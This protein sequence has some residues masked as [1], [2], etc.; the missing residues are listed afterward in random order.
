M[1]TFF[2]IFKISAITFLLISNLS[3]LL[4]RFID[5]PTT[6]FIQQELSDFIIELK[7]METVELDWI[8]Y[9]N[10]SDFMKIAVIAS[11]DQKFADHFGFDFDQIEKAYEDIERG[12]RFRGASTISQQTAKNIFLWKGQNII[13][14]GFEAYFTLLL[15]IYWSKER[16][17]EVY[18]NIAQ[19]GDKIYGVGKA[20]KFYFNKSPH[21]LTKSESALLAAVLPSPI[22]YKAAKPTA[23]LIGRRNRIMIQMDLI[24]GKSYLK[25][26]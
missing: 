25:R 15:E 17:L 23:F 26:L 22:R 14:K 4:F 24:G 11:E 19:F 13:R 20:S 1:K 12:K 16:I 10:I 9:D 18:L 8:R 6:A 21:R 2:R 3:V 5:L 7:P